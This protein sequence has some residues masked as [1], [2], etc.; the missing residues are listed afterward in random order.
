MNYG[1][2]SAYWYLRLNGFFLIQNFVIHRTEEIKHSSDIDL[3][4]IRLP[5]VFEEVGGQP[6]DWDAVLL[7]EL[8]PNLP[9]G[10]ICEVKTGD[11]DEK[12]LFRQHYLSYSLDRFGFQPNLSE[13]TKTIASNK[14]TEIEY[15][16]TRFQILKLFVS[17]SQAKRLDFLQLSIKHLR[18]FIERRIQNYRDKK[19]QDRLLFQSDFLG[20]Y[21]DRL[22]NE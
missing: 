2:T 8:N 7:E 11:F 6:G 22:F 18:A 1:E 14:L 20:E 16:G 4:G 21:I 9:T 5:Y 3:L 19:W 17:N 12:K 13:C 10:I 15:K